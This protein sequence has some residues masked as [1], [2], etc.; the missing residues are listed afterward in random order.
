[1][2]TGRIR[3]VIQKH[4]RGTPCKCSLCRI[5]TGIP[6]N[7]TLR[8]LYIECSKLFTQAAVIEPSLGKYDPPVFTSL[9]SESRITEF[10]SM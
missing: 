7:E 4:F 10:E 2:G 3:T 9:R 5:V 1:M 6:F 8:E